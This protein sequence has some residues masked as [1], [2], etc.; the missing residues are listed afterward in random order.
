MYFKFIAIP[1]LS[2]HPPYYSFIMGHGHRPAPAE[3]KGEGGRAVEANSKKPADSV[4]SYLL[5]LYG[6]F[7][8]VTNMTDILQ[9]SRPNIDHLIA[10]GD[11]PAAKIG[12]QYRVKTDDFVKWWNGRVQQTQ[13]N[14]L[15]G[16][17]PG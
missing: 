6:P 10:V 2:R 13:K 9:V 16:C 7:L 12:R 14:I 1:F 11:L 17:L 5:G 4:L 3:K 15:K 8:T